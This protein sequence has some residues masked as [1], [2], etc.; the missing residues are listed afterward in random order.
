MGTESTSN[1]Y[2]IYKV[3][4]TNT[5]HAVNTISLLYS[6]FSRA[7]KKDN[8]YDPYTAAK[9]QMQQ[10]RSTVHPNCGTAPTDC[11]PFYSDADRVA[12]DKAKA[13]QRRRANRALKH[14]LS[15]HDDNNNNSRLS[16][17]SQDSDY[18]SLFPRRSPNSKS[19]SPS[20][21]RLLSLSLSQSP[22]MEFLV[23]STSGSESSLPSVISP[24]PISPTVSKG[25]ILRLPK[26]C[27]E[28]G[29]QYPVQTAKY[30]CECGVRRLFV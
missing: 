19:R 21:T 26:F 10:L 27:H 5:K 8:S 17:I 22:Q 2:T 9:K 11:D 25:Q 4:D 29:S 24:N 30:C 18:C 6:S 16:N 15:E 23:G 3:S 13:L 12:G 14:Q 28:C 7:A 1:G 20:P